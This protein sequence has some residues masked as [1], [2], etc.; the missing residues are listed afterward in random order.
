MIPKKTVMYHKVFGANKTNS[1]IGTS[2]SSV[3]LCE[4]WAEPIIFHLY[5]IGSIFHH[6]LSGGEGKNTGIKTINRNN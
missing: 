6:L 5:M 4:V 3:I 1:N 2:P